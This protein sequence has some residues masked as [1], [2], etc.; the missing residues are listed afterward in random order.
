M[1]NPLTS[2]ACLAQIAAGSIPIPG[3]IPG[4]AGTAVVGA[5]GHAAGAAAGAAA[6]GA[7]NAAIGGLAGAIQDALSTI[8]RESVA[9]WVHLPSPDLTSDPVPQTLH[10]WL[11]PFTAAVAVVGILTAAG[12]MILT[13]KATPLADVGSGLLTMA[14][15][16]AVGTALPTLLLRAGDAYSSFV[17]NASTDQQFGARYAELLSFGAATGPGA[18]GILIVLGVLGMVAGAVQAILLIFR[19][20]A[21]IILAGTL[22]LAAA[23]MMTTLT[24][25]WLR[26][27]TG[28]LLALIFYKPA[29]ATVYAVGFLMIGRGGV[30]EMFVGFAILFL[31]LVTLPALMKFFTWTTGAVETSSGGGGF[32][33]A[34]I[35]G[36][37]AVGAIRAYGGMSA[38]D[39]ARQISSA[40]PADGSGPG[41]S[42]GGSSGGSPGGSSG[43]SPGGPSGSGQLADAS[44]GPGANPAAGSGAAAGSAPGGG[45]SAQGAGKAPGPTGSGTSGG[46]PAAAASPASGAAGSGAA[47]GAGAA[48]AAAGPV[49]TIVL[50]GAQAAHGAATKLADGAAP[51]GNTS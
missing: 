49:G 19:Q 8:A 25:P 29:A 43:G 33:G 34:V 22:P 40:G 45:T 14:I 36:A 11:L 30:Q 3:Q 4:A 37:A 20:G 13:R 41:G 27:V 23:G 47:S 38:G 46:G 7:A 39:Q 44:G 15:V 31:S 2:A 32:L 12:R 6:G 18:A 26:K 5:A 48:G 35:G 16:V 21:V 17:L 10:T 42:S 50:A 51:P 24:R 1:C 28:W 9:L